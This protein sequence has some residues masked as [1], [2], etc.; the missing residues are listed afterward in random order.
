MGGM[1]YASSEGSTGEECSP[2]EANGK[3]LQIGNL[4]AKLM[5]EGDN[6]VYSSR[7]WWAEDEDVLRAK[8]HRR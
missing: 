6:A 4:I 7:H 8:C 5:E 1:T 2:K 3:P